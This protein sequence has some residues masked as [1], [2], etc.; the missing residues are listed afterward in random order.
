MKARQT[1]LKQKVNELGARVSG[2]NMNDPRKE[3]LNDAYDDVLSAM[4][5]FKSLDPDSHVKSGFPD[6]AFTSAEKNLLDKI[7]KVNVILIGPTRPGL[8]PAGTLVEDFIPGIIRQLFRFAWL[9]VFIALTVSGIF[10]VIS[11]DNEERLTK[12]KHMIYFTLIGFAFVTLAFAI[13]KAVTNI[14]F[15][16]FI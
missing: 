1:E 9:A 13:V 14:D 11:F 3:D 12:A 16:N 8:V 10:M 6:A 4:S 2:F 7:N 5:D 15:F